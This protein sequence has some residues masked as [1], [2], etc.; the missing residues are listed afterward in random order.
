M[1]RIARF[2]AL[3]AAVA[4]VGFSVPAHAAPGHTVT[5]T[6]HQHGTFVEK[7]LK[8][9]PCTGDHLMTP[10]TPSVPGVQFTG[11]AVQHVT[12]FPAGDEVWFTFTETGKVAAV[13]TSGIT[14]SGHATA[15]GNFNMN[16]RNSNQTFT[17]S[18][19]V[20]ASDGSSFTF[21]QVTHITYNGNGDITVQF[22]KGNLTCS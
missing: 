12:Y 1:S 21:H 8:R 3:A 9:D 17:L 5:M 10:G 19:R 18:I 16:E 7:H 14:Y 4:L 2:A 13:G 22:G 15:W 20:S 6:K 11:N